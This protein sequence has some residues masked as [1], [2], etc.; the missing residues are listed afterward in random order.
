MGVGSKSALNVYSTRR[1]PSAVDAVP[2]QVGVSG[3]ESDGNCSGLG[4]SGEQR[5]RW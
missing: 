1:P 3:Q 4:S 2:Q 5:D